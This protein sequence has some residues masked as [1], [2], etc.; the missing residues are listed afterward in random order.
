MANDDVDREA[1][2]LTEEQI[3]DEIDSAQKFVRRNR[4]EYVLYLF[5]PAGMRVLVLGMLLSLVPPSTRLSAGALVLG[6]IYF[7]VEFRRL[8][9]RLRL[10]KVGLLGG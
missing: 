9:R 7:G 3:S 5:A 10:S 4:F 2:E 6:A 8:D 1:E